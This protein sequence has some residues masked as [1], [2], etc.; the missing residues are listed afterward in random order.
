M[1]TPQ[2]PKPDHKHWAT[3][4]APILTWGIYEIATGANVI[5]WGMMIAVG[6]YCIVAPFAYWWLPE[7]NSENA[8]RVRQ[9]VYVFAALLVGGIV[10]SFYD[11]QRVS[12]NV[13]GSSPNSTVIAPTPSA[14]PTLSAD[15]RTQILALPTAI[16]YRTPITTTRGSGNIENLTQNGVNNIANTGS[17]DT[18]N[19]G[20]SPPPT[21]RVTWDQQV[22]TQKN[23]KYPYVDKI[24]L[25]SDL[26]IPKTII[27]GIFFDQGDIL[28]KNAVVT[29]GSSTPT[30]ITM[31]RASPTTATRNTDNQVFPAIEISFTSMVPPFGPDNALIV[32]VQSSAPLHAWGW[33]LNAR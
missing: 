5:L 12:T 24:T 16:P 6:A 23:P 4:G 8:P 28:D 9:A 19:I 31:P 3:I 21:P 27:L 33:K 22:V 18:F 25:H 15:T 11:R 13:A 2:P 17:N 10:A 30:A 1:V 7:P 20:P 26:D 14:P 32:K 29:W